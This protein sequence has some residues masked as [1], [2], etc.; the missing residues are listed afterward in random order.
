MDQ[1]VVVEKMR[2]KCPRVKQLTEYIVRDI[3]QYHSKNFLRRF[4][5]RKGS[6]DRKDPDTK[7]GVWDKERVHKERNLGLKQGFIILDHQN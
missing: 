6:E 7:K 3:N 5:H 1:G 2:S 4:C